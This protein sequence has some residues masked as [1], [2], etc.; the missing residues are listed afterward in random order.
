MH[1]A[2]SPLVFAVLFSCFFSFTYFSVYFSCCHLPKR[3][4]DKCCD[5]TTL[6]TLH[7]ALAPTP[8]RLHRD[9]SSWGV[10]A[11]AAAAAWQHNQF[12]INCKIFFYCPRFIVWCGQCVL[13][14]RIF[15]MHFTASLFFAL[16]LRGMW[17]YLMTARRFYTDLHNSRRMG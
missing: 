1:V 17:Y 9:R 6:H 4:L 5:H 16:L 11:A 15:Q 13:H 7:T 2:C 12:L 3:S 8:V 14:F 10:V